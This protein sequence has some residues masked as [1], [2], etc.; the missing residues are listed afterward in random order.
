VKKTFALVNHINV[1]R[2]KYLTDHWLTRDFALL[3]AFSKLQILSLRVTGRS[4]QPNFIS[5][6]ILREKLHRSKRDYYHKEII[7]IIPIPDLSQ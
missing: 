2:I 3:F 4:L 7:I 1:S 5:G 6:C